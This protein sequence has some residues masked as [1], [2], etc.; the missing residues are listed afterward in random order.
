[1]RKPQRIAE[2]ADGRSGVTALHCTQAQRQF[3]R[4]RARQRVRRAFGWS[5]HGFAALGFAVV[6][7]AIF[8]VF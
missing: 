7:G 1:M 5:Y 4:Y 6:V 2:A 8:E 3:R